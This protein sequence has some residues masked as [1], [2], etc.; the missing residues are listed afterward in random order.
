MTNPLTTY[1]QQQGVT[2]PDNLVINNTMDAGTGPGGTNRT[3][4]ISYFTNDL[5]MGGGLTD[6]VTG[7]RYSMKSHIYWLVGKFDGAATG[8][9]EQSYG[10]IQVQIN[11]HDPCW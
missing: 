10:V 9:Y 4:Q 1:D 5:S 8:Y 11:V 2:I 6:P 3:F 7:Q